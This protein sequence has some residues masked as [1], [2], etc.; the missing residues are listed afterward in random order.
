MMRVQAFPCAL[1]KAD[2]DALKR[3]SGR[4]YRNVLI[5]P[6][7]IYRRTGHWRSEDAAKRLEEYLGGPTT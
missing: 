1:A 4:I 6:Y 2:A 3:A 5:W 7:R